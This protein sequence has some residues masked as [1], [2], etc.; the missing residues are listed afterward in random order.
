MYK[1]RIQILHIFASTQIV[2]R[3]LFKKSLGIPEVSQEKFEDTRGITR[4][5]ED[6]RGITRRFEDTRRIIRR[7][8]DTRGIT[9]SCKWE[10]MQ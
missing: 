6:T 8:E 1:Q 10:D 3:D 9:R 7:F 5:F 2:V 4:S